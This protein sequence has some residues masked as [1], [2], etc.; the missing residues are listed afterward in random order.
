MKKLSLIL[1]IALIILTACGSNSNG[2]KEG[3][4][5]EMENGDTFNNVNIEVLTNNFNNLSNDNTFIIIDHGDDFIQAAYSDDTYE[6]EYSEDGTLYEAK[7]LLTKEQ[8]LKIFK[9]YLNEKEGWKNAT[10]WEK[11]DL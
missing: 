2:V 5:I 3:Y 9:D 1:T 6:V 8:A 7:T 10:E 11:M 4:T